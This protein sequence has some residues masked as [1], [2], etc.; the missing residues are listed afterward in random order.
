MV[1][2]ILTNHSI[3]SRET[4]HSITRTRFHLRI[5]LENIYELSSQSTC[6]KC[7]TSIHRCKYL[8]IALIRNSFIGSQVTFV[9][10]VTL[11]YKRLL[12][13]KWG[14]E[15]YVFSRMLYILQNGALKLRPVDNR[16]ITMLMFRLNFQDLIYFLYYQL[17][18]V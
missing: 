18:I 9:L 11:F 15:L 5:S 6:S 10:T 8:I 2:T 17:I 16:S 14:C 3:A 7:F 1:F 4:H 13:L 12:F